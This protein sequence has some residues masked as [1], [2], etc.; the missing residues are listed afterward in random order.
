VRLLCG[1]SSGNVTNAKF[2]KYSKPVL[3]CL[4]EN[5]CFCRAPSVT[6]ASLTLASMILATCDWMH[7][8]CTSGYKQQNTLCSSHASATTTCE[9]RWPKQG[10]GKDQA[11]G[12]YKVTSMHMDV[13]ALFGR[14]VW[15]GVNIYDVTIHPSRGSRTVAFAEN[16][17]GGGFQKA[18]IF[19]CTKIESMII[20]NIKQAAI[21]Y[22]NVVKQL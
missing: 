6:P 20:K 16:F 3:E 5:I 8:S 2:P 1:H 7:A 14:S 9:Q 19:L 21:Q 4:Y 18:K 15:R 10:E 11:S 17:H 22:V 12:T 13:R